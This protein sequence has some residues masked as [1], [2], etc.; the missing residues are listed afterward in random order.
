MERKTGGCV[1]MVDNRAMMLITAMKISKIIQLLLVGETAVSHR[2][3]SNY[4]G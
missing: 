2:D 1:T 4:V 3:L